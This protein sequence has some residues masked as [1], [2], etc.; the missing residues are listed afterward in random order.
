M[1]FESGSMSFRMFYLAHPLPRDYVQ[2]FAA[3]AAPPLNALGTEEMHGWVGWRHLLDRKITEESIHLAGLLR[4]TLMRAQRRIPEALLRAECRMEELARMQAEGRPELDRKTRSAI[5]KEVRER[6][7]PAMPPELKG[8][9]VAHAPGDEILYADALSEKQVDAFV[10][11]VRE[12]LG[13]GPLPVTPSTAAIRRARINVAEIPVTSFSPECDD[14]FAENQIGRD[15]LTW[16]W[17]YS[18]VRTGMIKVDDHGEFGVMLEGPLVFVHGEAGG[19]QEI[20]LRRGFPVVS[21]EAKAALLSGKK[22]KRAYLVMVRG[23]ET[24]RAGV[25][26][27]EFLFRGLKLPEGE[28]L[29]FIS[30]FQARMTSLGVFRD[31][32]FALFDRFLKERIDAA[33]WRETQKGIHRWV[34]ERTARK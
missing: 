14:D 1:G 12:T 25:D 3:H 11:N 10:L 33:A 17:F 34:R 31:V 23:Q 24:W 13:F 28:K 8:M 15:F 22:L 6:L 18:E 16:L 7:L 4:L 29:D 9:H 5:R 27:D 20:A 19:A 32:F 26:A 21:A 2:R 30:M